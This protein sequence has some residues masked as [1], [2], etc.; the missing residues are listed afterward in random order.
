MKD[1]K[2]TASENTTPAPAGFKG[3]LQGIQD[4]ITV[5][6]HMPDTGP[7]EHFQYKIMIANLKAMRNT[8]SQIQKFAQSQRI[9]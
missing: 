5:L 7:I 3:M 9:K 1:E 8:I 2:Q 4:S 6:S